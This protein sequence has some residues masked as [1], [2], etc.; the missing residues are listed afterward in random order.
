[1]RSWISFGK[2]FTILVTLPSVSDNRI[3]Q[4]FEFSLSDPSLPKRRTVCSFTRIDFKFASYPS[5]ILMIG[6]GFG[7]F[8][9]GSRIDT[10]LL[11]SES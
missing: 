8:L 6:A 5:G 9:Y 1:M 10:Y 7:F 2:S 3:A 11:V 4:I